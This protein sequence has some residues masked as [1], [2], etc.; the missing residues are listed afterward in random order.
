MSLKERASTIKNKQ[1][2]APKGTRGSERRKGKEVEDASS[3]H[4]E[5]DTTLEQR[6]TNLEKRK[7]EI[8]MQRELEIKQPKVR[9]NRAR[10]RKG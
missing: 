1:H 9:A 10:K 5:E 6:N 2:E 7:Q 3:D 4:E 8:K